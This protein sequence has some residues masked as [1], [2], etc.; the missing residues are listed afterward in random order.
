METLPDMAKQQLSTQA[1]GPSAAHIL[2]VVNEYCRLFTE[3]EPEAIGLL[4]AEDAVVRDPITG[5]PVRGRAAIEAWYRGAFEQMGG[6]MRMVLDG[7]V[8]IAGPYAAFG[9]VVTPHNHSGEQFTVESLD[10]MHFNAEGLVTSMDA[11][12]GETNYR[13]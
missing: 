5:P 12:F 4:Y 11:Y 8:R 10:V 7:S 1:G 13:K 9:L 3:G 6:G 2:H